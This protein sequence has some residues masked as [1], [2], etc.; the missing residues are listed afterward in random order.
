[1]PWR[2]LAAG[3]TSLPRPSG[4]G[5]PLATRHPSRASFTVRWCPSS[6]G[7]FPSGRTTPSPPRA[8][9]AS[10]TPSRWPLRCRHPRAERLRR[11]RC[12]PPSRRLS[13]L[14]PP[15]QWPASGQ[16]HPSRRD[17]RTGPPGAPAVGE[18]RR[19][20][21]PPRRASSSSGARPR[22]AAAPTAVREA[23]VRPVRRRTRRAGGPAPTTTSSRTT[24][25]PRPFATTAS[26][27]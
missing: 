9:P 27:L 17:S 22:D 7:R 8:S 18:V 23:V 21:L 24:R 14:P 4:T 12:R 10:W 3:R 2:P 5:R 19:S 26:T 6:A 15:R 20:Q 1:M 13:K 11:P 16:R 25:T